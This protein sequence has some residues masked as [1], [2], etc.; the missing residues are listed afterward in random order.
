MKFLNTPLHRGAD[1]SY[2]LPSQ[3]QSMLVAEQDNSR[4]LVKEE[5]QRQ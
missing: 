4:I 3:S 5:W 2:I 1:E